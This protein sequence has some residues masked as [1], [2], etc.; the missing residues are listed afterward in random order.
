MQQDV[1]RTGTLEGHHYVI[2]RT[3]PHWFKAE[4]FDGNG[5]SEG[6]TCFQYTIKK[7]WSD[8]IEFIAIYL[9]RRTSCT[10]KS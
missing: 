9:Q 6:T 3:D 2:H 4:I 5:Q 7:A 8:A 10:P 1:V